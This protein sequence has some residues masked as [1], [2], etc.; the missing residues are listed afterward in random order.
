MYLVLCI[1]AFLVCVFSA[2]K[3][4]NSSL[5]ASNV[6]TSNP[7]TVP[8]IKGYAAKSRFTSAFKRSF[9][10]REFWC[11]FGNKSKLMKMFFL[12]KIG[13]MCKFCCIEIPNRYRFLVNHDSG[14][15]CSIFSNR[16]AK[17]SR[18]IIGVRAALVLGV[19]GLIRLPEIAYRVVCFVPVY[20]IYLTFAPSPIDKQPSKLMRNIFDASNADDLVASLVKTTS[21]TPFL[22][23]PVPT[24]TRNPSENASFRVVV[25][26]FTQ[27]LCGKIGLSHDT[28]PSLIG[29]RPAR[30]ISTGGLRYFS[31]SLGAL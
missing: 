21:L 27:T 22:E 4:P 15:V 3:L 29:Q 13:F 18:F 16:N 31:L 6:W 30:V 17:K 12:Q 23:S 19:L 25:K 8:L 28:V 5:L 20:V 11:H 1:K 26:Q 2:I 9:N 10:W 7:L 24:S 14:L